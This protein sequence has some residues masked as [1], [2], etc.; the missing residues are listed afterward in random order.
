MQ[1]FTGR[2]GQARAL[3]KEIL[4]RFPQN[5]SRYVEVF[6]GDV[7]KTYFAGTKTSQHLKDHG[8]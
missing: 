3:R 6:E 7:G 4:A 2:I 5:Y 8:N 1:G